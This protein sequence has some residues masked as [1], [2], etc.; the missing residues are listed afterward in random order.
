MLH[1]SSFLSGLV[2]VAVSLAA[3][4]AET[5]I[6]GAPVRAPDALTLVQ[7]QLLATQRNR[8]TLL[9]QRAVEGAQADRISASARPN[10]TLTLGPSNITR[11][12]PDNYHYRGPD[13]HF[14]TDVGISQ[15][16]ERGN[17][18]ELRMAAADSAI[19]ASRNES[20]DVGRQQRLAVA[21]AY[22][23]LVLAQERMRIA[24]DNA[25]L[26]GKTLDAANIR[27]K[28]G[29]IAATEVARLNVDALRAQN[30]ARAARG[31]QEKAQGALGYLIG[32]EG[33]ARA[34][35]AVD[36]WPDPVALP[37]LPLL[38]NVL[39]GRAD[40]A[41]AQARIYEAE[42]NRDLARAQ[43][44]RDVTVGAQFTRSPVDPVS[45]GTSAN[46]WGLNFGVPLFLNYNFEGEIRRAEVDLQTA[47]DSLERVKA[48]AIG[49]IQ[50]ARTDLETAAEQV[51]RFRSTLLREAQRAADGA[52]FAYSKGALGVIDLLDAR[53][54][55]Y[56]ARLEAAATQTDYA[57]ALAAWDAAVAA[58]SVYAQDSN[59]P[60]ESY[61]TPP[62]R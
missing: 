4:A 48:L 34:L 31:D 1:N 30:D 11:R 53:R 54:Q 28:A 6:V 37:P 24:L 36:G 50:R 13:R 22:Y 49:E 8:E 56:A 33:N 18:R 7:A 20:A 23:D 52:E 38:T 19:Q 58:S 43:R 16:F 9:A 51:E 35:R 26:F 45:N 42:K 25:Q 2:F 61:A 14:A 32:A 27:L 59:A 5:P 44:T 40:V 3:G 47:R 17:K 46:T 55:L 60:A 41:A 21:N 57:Q 15:V 62:P 29:D 12:V 39:D 10:P